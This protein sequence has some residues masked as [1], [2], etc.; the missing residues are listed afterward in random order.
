MVEVVIVQ[1]NVE[2]MVKST[3]SQHLASNKSKPYCLYTSAW[4]R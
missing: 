1:K 4:D 2:P 3:D